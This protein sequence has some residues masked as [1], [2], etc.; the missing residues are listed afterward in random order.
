MKAKSSLHQIKALVVSLSTSHRVPYIRDEF[1]ELHFQTQSWLGVE[2]YRGRE[3]KTEKAKREREGT[4]Q[5]NLVVPFFG[6]MLHLSF[7]TERERTSGRKKRE[8]GKERDKHW[9]E[10]N[11]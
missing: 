5:C 6:C 9:Q 1:K 10:L 11:E 8:G 4:R 2:S 7:E 3:S